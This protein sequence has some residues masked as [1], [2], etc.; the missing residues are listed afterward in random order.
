MK[1]FQ[2]IVLIVFIAAAIFG[3]LVFSGTIPLGSNSAN[4]G[5]Q[6]TVVLWGTQNAQT[7]NALLDDFNRANPTM[8][9]K[10][11]QKPAD[12]FDKDLLEAMASGTGPDMFF[13]TDGLAFKYSNK[14]FTIPYQSFS[15]STFQS[16]FLTAGEVFLSDKGVIAFPIAIDPLMMYYDRS[17]FDS[18][19][20]VY[21]PAYWDD[22]GAMVPKLTKKDDRGA[23]I[24]SAIGL[25]QFSNINSAKEILSALFMQAGSGIVAQKNGS[26]ASTLG[27]TAQYDLGSVLKFYTSF[28]DPLQSVYSWNKSFPLAR[29]AFSSQKL[30][31]YFGFASELRDLI[32]KNPNQNFLTA[33]IPQIKNSGSKLTFAHVTGIAVASASKNL[34][35]AFTAAGL[36]ASGDFAA[37]LSDNLGMVPARRDL[38]KNLPTDAYMS[39]FYSSALFARSWLDPSPEDSDNIFRNMVDKVLSNSLSPSESV[40]DASAKLDLLLAR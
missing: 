10:Y 12:S 23:I 5:S 22:L 30:A 20:I 15:V 31:I 33:P 3:I 4:T 40:N 17:A 25:G 36:L 14:I 9:V 1:N 18:N 16:N 29:D 11:A 24:E 7:V 8:V 13:I 28:A 21:P 35:T 27:D 34:N 6:G 38:V 39:Q 2:I 32:N 37:K 19:G 26:F